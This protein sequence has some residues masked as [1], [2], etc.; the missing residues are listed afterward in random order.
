MN[1]PLIDQPFL[2]GVS[3]PSPARKV[4]ALDYYDGPTEGLLQCEMGRVYCFKILAW[5]SETQDVR[6]FSLAPMPP[7][8]FDRLAE[9]FAR[10]EKPQWP[11]WIPSWCEDQNEETDAILKEAGPA[12][13]VIAVEDLMGTILAA[14]RVRPEDVRAVDDW[15]SFLG[16]GDGIPDLASTPAR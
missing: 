6:V 1:S 8:A 4:L 3:F 12:E 11:V 5:D 15:R 13:W 7:A 10:C 14:K 16:L 2:E 9:L